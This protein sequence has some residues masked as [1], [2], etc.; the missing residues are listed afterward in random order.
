MLSLIISENSMLSL[1]L[2]QRRILSLQG[3]GAK[4]HLCYLFEEIEVNF[5]LIALLE[6]LKLL[7]MNKIKK[8]RK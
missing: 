1:Y 7:K 8:E 2:L 6:L 3:V 4:V 5:C